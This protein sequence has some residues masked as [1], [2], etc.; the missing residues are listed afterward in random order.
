MYSVFQYI[1]YECG[2]NLFVNLFRIFRI[3]FTNCTEFMKV[4][5]MIH[6]GNTIIPSSRAVAS[7]GPGGGPPPPDKVLAPPG[8]PGAVYGE[9]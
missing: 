1:K 9:F 2:F 5:S 8:W 3:I 4:I 6:L 7:V